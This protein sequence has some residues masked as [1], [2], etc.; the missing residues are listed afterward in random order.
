MTEEMN[1]GASLEEL[2]AS[3][4]I[5]NIDF[6]QRGLPGG[7]SFAGRALISCVFDGAALSDADF[8]GCRVER[9]SFRGADLS[10]AG[11]RSSRA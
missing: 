9:C 6:T 3:E 1:R 4:T 2:L 8:T 10:D 7:L 5:E 11:A